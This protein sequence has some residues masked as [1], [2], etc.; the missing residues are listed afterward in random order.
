[1]TAWQPAD[2]KIRSVRESLGARKIPLAMTEC[3]FVIP[4]RDRGDVLASWAAGVPTP[5]S[6]TTISGTAT[7]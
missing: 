6:S 3:H 4:G 5:A 2:A 7:S 1:M